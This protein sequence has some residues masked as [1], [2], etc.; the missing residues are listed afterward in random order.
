MLQQSSHTGDYQKMKYTTN[1]AILKSQYIWD[2]DYAKKIREK[3]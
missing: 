2:Q 1:C 3:M